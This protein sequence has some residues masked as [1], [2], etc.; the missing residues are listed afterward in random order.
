MKVRLTLNLNLVFDLP[1]VVDPQNNKWC[2]SL[3]I[4]AIQVPNVGFDV[5]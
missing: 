2:N 5:F 1:G 4:L 3:L